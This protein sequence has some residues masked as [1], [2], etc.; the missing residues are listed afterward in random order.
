MVT[1]IISICNFTFSF[2]L[3]VCPNIR[4]N[5]DYSYCFLDF[6]R[7]DV[8]TYIFDMYTSVFLLMHLMT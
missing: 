5:I 1:I 3:Y 6:Y 7:L 8:V 2:R 4:D